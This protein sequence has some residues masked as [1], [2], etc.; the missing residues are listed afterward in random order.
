[1]RLP[2][3]LARKVLHRLE[4]ELDGYIRRFCHCSAGNIAPGIFVVSPGVRVA[5]LI[6]QTFDGASL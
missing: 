2:L 6:L 3:L 4:V 1:M 5:T